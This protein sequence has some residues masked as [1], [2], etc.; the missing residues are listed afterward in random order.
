MAHQVCKQGRYDI[1]VKVN[2]QPY[3]NIFLYYRT[4]MWKRCRVQNHSGL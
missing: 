4:L 1:E 2:I 3:P